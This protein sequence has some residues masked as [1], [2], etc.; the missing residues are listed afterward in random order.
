MKL[1]TPVECGNLPVS[2]SLS[3]KAMI[4]GSN[5]NLNGGGLYENAILCELVSK[6]YR[7][8]YYN[9]NRLG[10]LDF[11]I[12]YNGHILPIEVK[13][14][15]DY[16]V[17]SALDRLLSVEDYA[18]KRAYVLSNEGNVSEKNGVTYMP[19]YNVMFF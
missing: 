7:V 16:T 8:Y 19:V 12:E 17:H 2:V 5:A 6:G 4:L 9:S 1:I 18:V 15:K 10:E 13:S 11:V 14:G 3:D